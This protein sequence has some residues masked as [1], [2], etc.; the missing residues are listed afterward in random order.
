MRRNRSPYPRAYEL[1]ACGE[2]SLRELAEMN[3][4]RAEQL[5][6]EAAIARESARIYLEAADARA[7][8]KRARKERRRAQRQAAKAPSP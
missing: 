1:K 6:Q 3:L 7:A 5:E 8:E 2:P 4:K